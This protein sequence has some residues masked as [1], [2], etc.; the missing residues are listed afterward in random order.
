MKTIEDAKM[1]LENYGLSDCANKIISHAK[2]AIYIE[3]DDVADE[4]DIPVGSSKIGGNPDLPNGVSW[5]KDEANDRWLSF[6]C[7]INFKEVKP[8]DIE[9]KLPDKGMLF[10]FYDWSVD[11]SPWGYDPKDAS[12]KAVIYYDGDMSC[13]H[14]AEIPEKLKDEGYF[15]EPCRLS[16]EQR[17]DIPSTYSGIMDIIG[18]SPED[19]DKYYDVCE[20]F[21]E[22]SVNKL[23]G[24]SNNIQGDMELEC[25]LVANGLY[26]GDGTGY[27]EGA[28]RGLDKNV[29]HWNLLLQIDSYE[30]LGL[31]WGD[32][33]RLYF[34]ITAEDLEARNFE[35]TWLILQCG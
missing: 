5:P 11:G 21:D 14:R 29:A 8:Y 34:W 31:M 19:S 28:K 25:E 3:L 27:E 10:F 9:N 4:N 32:C 20:E 24:H 22:E 16:F 18:L 12:G 23:L 1:M 13:L 26:C 6:L 35:K 7:Q 33:G 17:M 2:N 30:D 15:A